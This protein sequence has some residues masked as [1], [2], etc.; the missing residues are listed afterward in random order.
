MTS[1]PPS[2]GNAY[3]KHELGHVERHGVPGMTLH[4]ADPREAGKGLGVEPAPVALRAVVL[5][6]QRDFLVQDLAVQRQVCL[7]LGQV[8]IPL[9][10]L[11]AE[12]QMIAERCG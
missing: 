12:D 9:E 5:V 7:R 1:S 2:A 8:T 11:V 6:Q 10:D 4:P 3:P